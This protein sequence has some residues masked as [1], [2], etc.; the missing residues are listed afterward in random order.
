M[1][2]NSIQ[3]HFKCLYESEK[4]TADDGMKQTFTELTM[5]DNI[6]VK[7]LADNMMN[8]QHILMNIKLI[9]GL[10]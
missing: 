7:R 9:L 8:L 10:R 5:K 3:M 2:Q 1:A 6:H 4:I